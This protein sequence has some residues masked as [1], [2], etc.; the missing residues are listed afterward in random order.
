MRKTILII[1]AVIGLAQTAFAVRAKLQWRTYTLSDGTQIEL[2]QWGDEYFNCYR[3]K[4]GR[5][6]SYDDS[7]FRLL[8]LEEVQRGLTRSEKAWTRSVIPLPSSDWDSKRIYRQA[9]ILISFTD[10][11]FGMDSPNAY[12]ND[13]LN[14]YSSTTLPGTGSMAAYFRDQSGGKANFQFDVYGPVKVSQSSHPNSGNSGESVFRE[15]LEKTLD[16]LKVDFTPYDWNG[17]GEV[18][19][20]IF[21]TAGYCANGGATKTSKYLWPN[22]GFF[23]TVKTD[24]GLSITR[25]S[26][27]AEKWFNEKLCGIGTICHEFSHCLGLPDLYPTI[28]SYGFSVVDEWDLM[29]GGNYT[30]WGWCPPNYSVHEKSLFGW[31]TPEEFTRTTSIQN[32]KPLSDGGSAYRITKKGDEFYLLE[33]RQQRGWDQGL[34]G[35]GLLI[36][37]V[38]YDPYIWISNDVNNLVVHY[39]IVHADGMNYDEWEDYI[40]A[41]GLTNYADSEN[42]LNRRYLSTSPY[43]LKTE[44]ADVHECLDLPYPVTNITISADGLI[45]FDVTV[46]SGIQDIMQES[47]Q[48]VWYDLHGRRLS[49]KPVKKGVYICNK[50]K[51]AIR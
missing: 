49:D 45:S 48:D 7:G 50:K 28:R 46:S 41:N 14:T 44:T 1:L 35:K 51:I 15:A 9:V 36:T 31:L 21:I 33:N 19:Q 11:E 12:Y 38:N 3:A 32:L 29:D 10:E 2:T 39:D 42:N 43:P 30:N 34:P 24:N 40:K 16:S 8:S 37:Y 27:S 26:G 18:E 47:G 23:T 22:T 13:L 6:F 5:F 4:D 25:Y 20:V 17:D